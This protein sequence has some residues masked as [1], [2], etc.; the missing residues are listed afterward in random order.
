[1]NTKAFYNLFFLFTVLILL[2]VSG[3]SNANQSGGKKLS[4]DIQGT[5]TGSAQ[6]TGS[7]NPTFTL[8]LNTKEGGEVWGTITSMDGTFE[9]A[10]IADG[11]LVDKKVTFSATANGTNFRHGH[12]YTFEASVK[13]DMMEG[14]WK[15]IL[16]R[17]WGSF[18]VEREKKSPTSKEENKMKEETSSGEHKS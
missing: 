18:T 13:G 2:A 7:P 16:E 17:G 5:W 6:Q 4:L 3:C 9:E 8:K 11:K 10:I 15:D 14:I 1:M 12:T